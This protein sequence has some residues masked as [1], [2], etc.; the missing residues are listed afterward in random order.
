MRDLAGRVD[1]LVLLGRTVDDE[2]VTE[3]SSFGLPVVVVA[4][5][6]VDGADAIRASSGDSARDLGHHLAGHGLRNITFVGS[7]DRSP[8]VAERWEGVRD[9]LGE[10]G[11]DL[12]VAP[13]RMDEESGTRAATALLD[14]ADRPDALVC[15]NDEIALGAVVAAERAGLRVGRDIAITGWDD[16][17]AARHARPALTTVRQ[18]MRSLGALAAEVLD[19]RITGNR[20]T[21]RYESL[22]T[23]LVIRDSC[24]IHH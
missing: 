15:A 24:G 22:D 16:V 23:D 3:L 20:T 7:P 1:G 17:M 13:C 4:R 5:G 6:A 19:E 9:A 14:A 10:H 18:P 2:L 21:P 12:S 11:V 8:D